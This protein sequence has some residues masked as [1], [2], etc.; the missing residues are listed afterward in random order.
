MIGYGVLH[1]NGAHRINIKDPTF[2]F[3]VHGHDPN[4]ANGTTLDILVERT[5]MCVERSTFQGPRSRV[6][7][8]QCYN[9]SSRH[10][11]RTTTARM[12]KT[13]EH[14]AGEV[15][16]HDSPLGH[17]AQGLERNVVPTSPVSFIC[18]VRD[19]TTPCE[20]RVKDKQVRLEVADE[21]MQIIPPSGARG[22]PSITLWHEPR[23][24]QSIRS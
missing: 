13:S 16:H 9:Q 17:R 20:H 22:P 6:M 23:W 1:A 7:G 3:S 18:T 24:M 11:W 12:A 19:R 4:S 21:N 8:H 10:R 5:D 14:S 15:H 2:T